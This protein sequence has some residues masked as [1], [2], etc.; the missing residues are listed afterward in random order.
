MAT[1]YQLI[2]DT[3]RGHAIVRMDGVRSSEEVPCML[4]ASHQCV[5]HVGAA[6]RLAST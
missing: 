1:Q 4:P 3:M 6:S 5:L 2:Q